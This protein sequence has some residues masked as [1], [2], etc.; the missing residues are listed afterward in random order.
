MLSSA[1]KTKP[2][3]DSCWV[4]LPSAQVL[5][6]SGHDRVIMVPFTAT[7]HLSLLFRLINSN[8][9]LFPQPSRVEHGDSWLFG[10]SPQRDKG[11]LM[12]WCVFCSSQ[13]YK[14]FT[15]KASVAY[16]VITIVCVH[17]FYLQDSHSIKNTQFNV[18]IKIG[19]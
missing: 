7:S 14:S 9:A 10:V 13:T 4:L 15:C 1:E 12:A 2:Y 19:L 18:V 11:S 16:G 6:L 5:C 3:L 8:I 17:E